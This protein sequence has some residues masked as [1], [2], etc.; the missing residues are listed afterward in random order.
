MFNIADWNKATTDTRKKL[1][2]GDKIRFIRPFCDFSK[3]F[4]G[5]YH[6]NT[7]TEAMVHAEIVQ[8]DKDGLFIKINDY[9]KEFWKWLDREINFI[10]SGA[11]SYGDY[12]KPS[13]HIGKVIRFRY[14]T[15]CWHLDRGS[16]E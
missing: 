3:P 12:I 15:W 10:K 16:N 11:T 6:L 13:I 8:N 5:S 4:N 9:S 7:D 1:N 14:M 2:V